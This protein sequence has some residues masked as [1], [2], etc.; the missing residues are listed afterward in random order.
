MSQSRRRIFFVA[1]KS[2]ILVLWPTKTHFQ[3]SEPHTTPPNSNTRC[4]VAVGDV[5]GDLLALDLPEKGLEVEDMI[6]GYAHLPTCDFQKWARNDCIVLHKNVTRWYRDK[7]VEVFGNMRQGQKWSQL[8][9]E[10]KAKI[11][12]SDNSFYDKWRHFS[13][14]R[15]S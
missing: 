3:V 2:D 12:Y 6:A 9:S 7:D 8:S 11:E 14:S 13:N 10:D 1:V 5:L 15:P 4:Y